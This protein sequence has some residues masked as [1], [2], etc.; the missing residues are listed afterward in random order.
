MPSGAGDHWVFGIGEDLVDSMEAPELTRLIRNAAGVP[1]L[2][3]RIHQIRTIKFAAEM[4][5]RFRSG[6]AFL[7]GDAA[8]RVTPRG[9]TGMNTAIADGYHLGWKLSWVLKGWAGDEL[10]DFSR[11]SPPPARSCRRRTCG[12]RCC[13][14]GSHRQPSHRTQRC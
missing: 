1:D 13:G 3:P 12:S 5:E 14:S 9:G 6:S 8:H 7:I 2:R 4:A 10:L 11:S